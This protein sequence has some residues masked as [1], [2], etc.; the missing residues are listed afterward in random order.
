MSGKV[1][2]QAGSANFDVG[3]KHQVGLEKQLCVV[4]I[5]YAAATSAAGFC[6]WLPFI[7]MEIDVL[8]LFLLLSYC[9]GS[10]FL[11]IQNKWKLPSK[12]L[13]RVT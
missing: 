11:S 3:Q 2:W 10:G 1:Q 13:S 6:V 4:T 8:R 9:N 12:K 7:Q 5:Q